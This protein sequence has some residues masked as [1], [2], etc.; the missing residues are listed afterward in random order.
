MDSRVAISIEKNKLTLSGVL[1]FDSVLDVDAQGREWINASALYDCSL[2]L[3]LV[4]YSSSAGI[5]L[6]LGWM[7]LAQQQQ[8]KLRIVRLPMKM[9]ILAKVS[10]LDDFLSC[11]CDNIS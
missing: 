9:L 8:K 2:D 1:D 3:G 6:L 7:R 5:A 11:R 4:T 10:G